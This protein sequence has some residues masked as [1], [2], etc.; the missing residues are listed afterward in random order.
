MPSFFS[1]RKVRLAG[2]LDLPRV[3]ARGGNRENKKFS[4]RQ[5]E[6]RRFVAC[7]KIFLC[8]TGKVDL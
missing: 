5:I 3:H 6:P 7:N 1:W 8:A 2:I 4:I